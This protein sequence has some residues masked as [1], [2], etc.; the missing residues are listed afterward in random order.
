MAMM[1]MCV[2]P[3]Q[4]P[5]LAHRHTAK[6]LCCTYNPDPLARLTHSLAR[7][8]IPFS[9]SRSSF[10]MVYPKTIL[11]LITYVYVWAMHSH[12]S[13][14]LSQSF[15]QCRNWATLSGGMG[16]TN[17]FVENWI[18]NLFFIWVYVYLSVLLLYSC[19]YGSHYILFVCLK[20]A[21]H[22]W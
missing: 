17:I 3:L 1:C 14:S 2:K 20:H 22:C 6:L 19:S 7:S 9:V 18:L 5:T 8:V 16:L 10:V 12:L 13:L 15:V 21:H 11:L 4:T